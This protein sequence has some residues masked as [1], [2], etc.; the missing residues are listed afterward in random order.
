ML[1]DPMDFDRRFGEGRSAALEEMR[2]VAAKE[3]FYGNGDAVSKYL[4]DLG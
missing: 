2:D 3:G 4:R 1:S